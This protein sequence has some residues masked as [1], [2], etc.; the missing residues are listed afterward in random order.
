MRNLTNSE[1][2]IYINTLADGEA[3]EIVQVGNTTQTVANVSMKTNTT[4][5]TTLNDT[6]I[7][8]IADGTTGKVVQYITIGDFKTA[9]T[10]WSLTN[11]QLYPD[12]TDYNVVVG[13]TT[14]SVGYGIY[15]FDKDFAIKRPAGSGS[16]ASLKLIYDNFIVSN[17]V[18]SAGNMFWAGATSN[19][20]FDKQVIIDTTGAELSNGTNTYT[21]PIA[22]GILALTTD[23]TTSTNF[24]TAVPGGNTIKVGNSA[25][26]S[27]TTNLQLYTSASLKIFNTS[28]VNV[29]TF[30]PVSNTCDLDLKGGLITNATT[31]TNTIW[32][33][34]TISYDYGGTGKS[35]LT[36]QASKV[37]RVNS[38]ENGY[39]FYT[40]PTATTQYW[41][42][43]NNTITPL[44][45]SVNKLDI[46]THIRLET[47]ST[48]NHYLTDPNSGVGESNNY[49]LYYNTAS[50]LSILNS[51]AESG[52][53]R[54][55]IAG[56]TRF[57]VKD[58]IINSYVNMSITGTL[59]TTGNTTVGG[60]LTIGDSTTNLYI[61]SNNDVV[62]SYIRTTQQISLEGDT[63]VQ[64]DLT[65]TNGITAS[66]FTT[67]NATSTKILELLDD[68]LR[69]KSNILSAHIIQP[70]EGATY[71]S[72]IIQSGTSS[73]TVTHNLSL[74][75][76]DSNWSGD[77][78][79]NNNNFPILGNNSGH[80]KLH[81]SSL[82]DALTTATENSKAIVKITNA[83]RI[84]GYIS[85]A[86]DGL[87]GLPA[88][89]TVLAT[90]DSKPYSNSYWQTIHGV[91]SSFPYWDL[92]GSDYDTSN[93]NT[94]GC[95]LVCNY[96]LFLKS[97]VMFM[98][99]DRRI[100]HNITEID[101]NYALD[102]LNKINM[103]Q[104][105]LNDWFEND[106]AWNY[107]VIAQE[108]LEHFPQAVSR[109]KD[110]LSN[111]MS[112]VN[113]N[114]NKIDTDKYEMVIETKEEWGIKNG[115]M[116]KFYCSNSENEKSNILKLECI[117][118]NNTFLIE[119]EYQYVLCYGIETDDML[120][121]DKQKIYSLSHSAIQQLH[122]NNI[123]QQVEIDNLK[124]ELST[125]KS[126]VDKLIN[127]PSF[128]SFKESLV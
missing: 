80:F 105:K 74:T 28:N 122:K 76:Y 123:K 24:G 91:S 125:Y 52:E 53:C 35:T 110:Y 119:K 62:M 7:L 128:K 48:N 111:V 72:H 79:A 90:T 36:N 55:N 10:L 65:T 124:T 44:N 56:A 109:H 95:S 1:G 15:L 71:P 21:L 69:N 102:I 101:D 114:Y 50:T 43:S 84:D 33:G 77:G 60:M 116:V 19:Y 45:T 18:D 100:K 92:I 41:S 96:A 99:C 97:G 108:V 64:G 88:D 94:T 127:A 98:A 12:S 106:Y 9:G 117:K 25:G 113:V 47:V 68:R 81:I 121:V 118:N 83:M 87:T 3:I 23:I 22:D 11:N 93:I 59:L 75:N 66:S 112:A 32:N 40:I 103:Y 82:G 89:G 39:D 63:T 120:T 85:T 26:T 42:E 13:T 20:N 78:Y 4:Q 30:T 37:L 2:D 104:F 61:K 86:G 5:A 58:S 34:G 73:T 29:A 107:N 49:I 51:G 126:I 67:T 46:G 17:S 14:N 115:G 54:M 16:S 57:S 27:Q 8:I 6:D 38:N 70:L 31:S